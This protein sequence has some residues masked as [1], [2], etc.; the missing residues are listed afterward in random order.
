MRIRPNRQPWNKTSIRR[1]SALKPGC[2][3][4]LMA[5]AELARAEAAEGE[6]QS[7]PVLLAFNT[8]FING[9]GR[10]PD[11]SAVLSAGNAL[12]PGNYRVDVLVNGNLTGRRDV[13]FLQ[14]ASGKVEACIDA[15]LLQA[16][17]VQLQSLTPPLSADDPAC[18]D[19][20]ALMDLAAADYD[21]NRLQL[22]LSIPQAFLSRGARGYID[23]ALWD[24]G[25][26]AAY[27]N[28]QFNGNESRSSEPGGVNRRNAFLG[29]QNGVNLG[30]WRLRNDSTF[31]W[32]DGQSMS[33]RSNRSVLQRDLIGWKSQLALG[34]QYADSTLFDSVRFRGAQLA[35]DDAML[36]DGER[37][38][39][40]VVRGQ[41]QSNAV[42]EVRQN[43]YTLYRAN[44]PPGPFELTDIFPSGSNGDLEITVT[45]ADGSKRV[46]QQSFSSL[47]LM[48][49]KGRWRYSAAFGEYQGS[50]D[51]HPSF[52]AGTL[53]Y[54]AGDD[55]TVAAGFQLTSNFQAVNLGVG[56]NTPL[57]ALSLDF[58]QS[59]SRI[60]GARRQG[61]SLRLLYA[62]TFTR[63][64]TNLTLAAY[65]YSTSGYRSFNDHANDLA[66]NSQGQFGRSRSR[67]DLSTQQDLGRE[68]RFGSLYLNLS[69]QSYWGQNG[70]SGS[71]GLGYGN[72]WKL[73]GYNFTLSRSRDSRPGGVSSN[74]VMLTF[75]VPLG[76]K[77]RSPRM[78]AN[79]SHTSGN[80][81]TLQTGVSGHLGENTSYSVQL[82]HAGRNGSTSG[83]LSV[84]HNADFVQLSAAYN[85]ARHYQSA[86]VGLSGAIVAHGGGV[87]LSRPVGDTFALLQVDGV[88]GPALRTGNGGELGRN[89]YAVQPYAQPYRV[90]TL[91]LDTRQLG[92]DVELDDTVKLVVPRRG[93]VVKG[94]FKARSGQRAQ[95]TL[96]RQ[97]GAPAPFGASVEDADGKPLGIVDPRGKVLALL[98]R[99]TG[100]LTVKWR[101]G[102]CTAD[103]RL[104][105]AKAGRY[106][107]RRTLNCG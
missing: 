47:P 40:P 85:A 36:P 21:A 59:N 69:Q 28:Y 34:E 58:T 101:G 78:Y 65:R 53:V 82:G 71:V 31:N 76:P 41:A 45:E 87:N 104:P 95:F 56:A 17:G 73:L 10:M 43:G 92:A 105:P 54:G 6:A 63:T 89:G 35:S 37:G 66:G 11:L 42:V 5:L 72:N 50:Q 61:Q 77:P 49:R 62:K 57:G 8:N 3:A 18:L 12:L 74:Q 9:S 19:L 86:S 99:E 30:A 32:A 15:G 83:G 96:L 91:S 23:P 60:R 75:T 29:L 1:R 22:S 27:V 14:A 81:S 7:A 64:L 4:L 93:A 2:L 97:D 44:V 94:V 106:Y 80:G 51:V 20:P 102:Q 90:N 46:T 38:Y 25:V 67:I 68:R 88:T 13:L 48:L 84:N 103:Y 70:S 79:L 39:A 33:A 98:K 107:Q 55:S 16:A 100:R 52:A 26:A 24:A